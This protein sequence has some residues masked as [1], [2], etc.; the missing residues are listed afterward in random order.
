M[1]E[2]MK[3]GLSIAV[4]FSFIFGICLLINITEA[5]VEAK[6]YN[7]KFGT[8]YTT[9]DFYFSSR[10][11]KRYLHSGVQSKLNLDIIS[12]EYPNDRS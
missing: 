11:I 5:G 2:E 1:N 6:L 7:D 10:T 3:I 8:H 12:K 9:K 4:I